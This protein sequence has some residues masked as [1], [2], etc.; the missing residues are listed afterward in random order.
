M[1]SSRNTSDLCLEKLKANNGVI[2]ISLIPALTRSDV[3]TADTTHVVDHILYVA[4]RIG[5]DHIGIGS[6]FDGMVDCVHGLE[7]VSKFPELVATM[8]SKGIR[9]SDVEKIIGL[10]TIRVL[11]EVEDTRHKHA[12]VLPVLEDEVKQLWDENVRAFVRS[13][14]PVAEHDARHAPPS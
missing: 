13:R 14:Y 4:E 3:T 5:F 6:D 2:M 9:K 10:N 1:E 8:L 12:K 11:K 7:D